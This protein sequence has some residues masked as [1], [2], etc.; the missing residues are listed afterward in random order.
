MLYHV[1]HQH[2]LTLCSGDEDQAQERINKL[3]K[4]LKE[5]QVGSALRSAGVGV[6]SCII[7]RDEGRAPVRHSFQWSLDKLYYEEDPLQRHLEPPLSIFLELVYH[8]TLMDQLSFSFFIL[9]SLLT[10]YCL[11]VFIYFVMIQDK[12]KGYETI[13]YTPSRD[14]QWHLYTVVDKPQPIQRMFLR[15]LVRQSNSNEGFLTYQGQ[16]VGKTPAQKALPFTSRSLLRSLNAALEELELHG[17]NTSVKAD[18]AHM[19]LCILREQQ[20]EDL[21]PYNR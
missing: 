18:Y 17:H 8:Y 4:I 1:L 16:D 13:Q 7:Q 5:K 6:V 2:V 21:V 9:M 15:T 19:Y 11:C 14:R 20:I 10:I 3:A 12:L